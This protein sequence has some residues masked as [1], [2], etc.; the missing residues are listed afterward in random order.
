LLKPFLAQPKFLLQLLNA[1]EVISS[2]NFHLIPEINEL[3][4]NT[5][6][7]FKPGLPIVINYQH[8]E[9]ALPPSLA[10]R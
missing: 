10:A 3:F 6:N 4:K 1:H 7:I 2:G 9:Y 5:Q 8:S